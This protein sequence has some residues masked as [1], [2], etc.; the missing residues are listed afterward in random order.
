M[1]AAVHLRPADAAGA[2]HDDAAVAAAMSADACRF[3]IGHEDR[4]AI[5]VFA[6]AQRLELARLARSCQRQAGDHAIEVARR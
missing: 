1:M 3:G 4:F 2:D 6:L 5:G